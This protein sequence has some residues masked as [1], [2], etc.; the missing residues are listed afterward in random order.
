MDTYPLS[1]RAMLAASASGRSTPALGPG[2]GGPP[3]RP[4]RHHTTP[5]PAYATPLAAAASRMAASMTSSGV[6]SAAPMLPP[7]G[8]TPVR[9][10]W[11]RSGAGLGAGGGAI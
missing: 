7:V 11:L 1:S 2:S 8:A 4:R 3:K 9:R 5:Y 6:F 10:G